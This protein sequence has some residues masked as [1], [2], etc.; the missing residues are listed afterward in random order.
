IDKSG[1]KCTIA[2]SAVLH[3]YP[4]PN[5]RAKLLQITHVAISFGVS[6]AACPRFN[7]FKSHRLS[8]ATEF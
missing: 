7:P 1:R 3:A 6:Q 2:A 5:Y 4:F 8:I